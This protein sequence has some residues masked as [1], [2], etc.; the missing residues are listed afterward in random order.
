MVAKAVFNPFPGL[1]AF[2]EDEDYLF[3]GRE[4]QI[5]EL[6]KKLRTSHF[7]AVVG[8]S[9][10]G[11]SSLVKCGLL[12][13]L[14][15][16]YM[17]KA[18]SSWKVA[19][20]RPGDDPL[21]NLA[22][23]LAKPDVINE[24]QEMETTYAS[25]FEATLRRS[26]LGLIEV[27]KQSS[28]NASDN[29][30]IVVDQFEELFRFNKYEKNEQTEKRDSLT[31]TELLLNACNQQEVPIYIVLT[32]RSDFIGECTVFSGLAEAINRSQYLVP[33]MSRE[34]R[35]EAIT[36]PIAVGGG[37]ITPRLLTLL[38]ND[39]GESPDQLPILQHALLR[40]WRYWEE[41]HEDNEPLDLKHYHAIG[42]M[43]QALSQHAEEAYQELKSNESKRL[44]EVIFKAITEKGEGRQGIRRPTK[45]R[46]ICQISGASFNDVTNVINTFR[47]KG[48]SFLMPPEEVPL[49]EESIIDISHE[50]LMRIWV[51][52]IK[53]VEE[54]MHS[55]DIYKRLAEAAALFQEAKSGL[56]R[57]PELQFAL[58][59]YEENKP[60]RFWALRYDLSFER[61]I[62]FLKES[63]RQEEFEFLQKE[64][65]SKLKIR[66]IRFFAFFLGF[67]AFASLLLLI[68][69]M[70]LQTQAE[71]N[72][73]KADREKHRA[74]TQRGIAAEEQKKAVD[75]Q[76]K[77]EDQK[78][79]AEEQRKIAEEAQRK[80]EDQKI[81]A[82]KNSE[83]ARQSAI[84]ATKA[85]DS[86]E[87]EKRNAQFLQRR[88]EKS[89]RLA[90]GTALAFQSLKEPIN[91]ETQI[92]NLLALYA[93]RFTVNNGGEELNPTIYNAL[94][95]VVDNKLT[96]ARHLDAVRAVEISKDGQKIISGSNDKTVQI[97]NI[98]HSQ[99]RPRIFQGTNYPIRC[100][101]YSGDSTYLVAGDVEGNVI[102]WNLKMRSA[103]VIVS[104]CK[105]VINN[106][107][108]NGSSTVLIV[109]EADGLL[110]TL[111]LDD[112]KSNPAIVDKV[113]GRIADMAI[114]SDGFSLAVVCGDDF[115][116]VYDLKN[117]EPKPITVYLKNSK[118]ESVSFSHD[119]KYL[120][121]GSHDGKIFIWSR[122]DQ[123]Q[124]LFTLSGHNSSISD[125]VFSPDDQLLATASLD[126]T[127]R[128]WNYKKP[129]L[130]PVILSGHRGWVWNLAFSPDGHTLISA[131]EDRTLMSWT[132]SVRFLVKQ[133][134]EKTTRKFS[135]Q[136]WNNYIG[137]NVKYEEP[138]N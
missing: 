129:E 118:M 60:N 73:E 17:T 45:L 24:S 43:T 122:G 3:F 4:K 39:V 62:G 111:R 116:R 52:L 137:K 115:S 20:L 51:R 90:L 110:K 38:L 69:A 57:N 23:T 130:E 101:A 68:V 67:A 30:L 54:E 138:C 33:R 47:K 117:T 26:N 82:D 53:W 42:M 65:Q 48:I 9:G 76:R 11:K 34:E 46:E 71:Q 14:H 108:I 119:G 128:L 134:C 100:V 41:R 40:T 124:L 81:I 15:S 12:P 22:R 132:T 85:R 77:A 72:A 123:P 91:N 35:K 120:A 98:H 10:S 49:T 13:A 59:W 19:L 136:E 7:I 99:T 31:F 83:L 93:Y 107:A 106:I 102:V 5:D 27:V 75:A 126:R 25:I 61:A 133:T 32:M 16:G 18:G 104:L 94:A 66:R 70:N 105:G 127:I 50:S 21:G 64:R 79:V 113:P 95:R 96:F 6:L 92:S 56:W 37:S 84:D 28:R 109:G 80:A 29:L 135:L 36:G 125:L 89:E 2:E 87:L 97:W 63:K 58:K 114:A 55:A 86:A 8:T 78:I 121:T 44:S 1:R 112:L 131:S 88:A 103:P 74:E